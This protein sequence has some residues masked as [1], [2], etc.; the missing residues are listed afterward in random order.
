MTTLRKINGIKTRICKRKE[1]E[2][3]RAVSNGLLQSQG[4]CLHQMFSTANSVE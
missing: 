1:K 4:L 2:R 3:N